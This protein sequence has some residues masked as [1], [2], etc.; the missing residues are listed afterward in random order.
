[1]SFRLRHVHIYALVDNGKVILFDVGVNSPESLHMLEE[2][3]ATLGKTIH[4]I[5]QIFLTHF[6]GDHCGIAGTIQR[7]SGAVVRLS[8]ND[9]NRLKNQNR[10]DKFAE[11]AL[12]F[13]THHGLPHKVLG[14][15]VNLM[16]IFAKA[17][18]PF[19]VDDYLRPQNKYIFSNRTLEIIPAPGH[20]RG[21]MCFYFPED[22]ILLSGDH[23]LPEITPN[24][25]PDL[26]DLEYRPLR[27]F[28]KSLETV[29]ELPVKVV[30]PAHGAPFSELKNRIDEIKNHHTE[31]T[32]LIVKALQDRG[33]TTSF[34][35][36]RDIFGTDLPDFDQYLALN[37]TYVHL[38]DLTDK[39]IV[40]SEE[41]GGLVLYRV[42]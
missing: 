24:L 36:S 12:D 40:R 13:Y 6:H 17:T 22:K 31:R 30:Y 7:C 19:R 28:L 18:A 33:K 3:L 2:A 25:S 9:E 5:E 4:N 11:R 21:Q 27:S 8:E 34:E 14:T 39:G 32:R 26:F 35:I 15:M 41:V 37:E 20:T 29:R 10:M 1:M 38:I 23:V 16:A 42:V